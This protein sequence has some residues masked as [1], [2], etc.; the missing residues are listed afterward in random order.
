MTLREA[1]P[2]EHEIG[3]RYY[4]SDA[5]GVGGHLRDS[6]ADFRV[7]ELEAFDVEPVEADTGSYPHLVFRATLDGWD[8]NDFARELANALGVSRERVSWAGTKDKYAVTTQLFSVKREANDLPDLRDAEVEVLGRAGRPVLFGDL[9]GNAFEVVVRDPVAPANAD[10]VTDQLQAFGGV[11]NYFGHQRFGTRRAVTHEVGLAVVR[12]DWEG[13][14]LRYVGNPSERERPETREARQYVEETRDWQ[15]ALDRLPGGLRYERAMCHE[16][17]ANGADSPDDFRAALETLPSN[18]QRLLVHA[19][20]SYLYNEMLSRR[21]E[22]GLPFDR[23]VAGDVVCFTDRDAPA[24]LPVPDPDREQRVTEARVRTVT[25]HCER[26]RAFVTAPLV[27]TETE[28]AEGEQGD[29]ERAVM[30]EHDL[31]PT[32]FDLPG[33]FGSAGTRRAI[34]LPVSPAV[35]HDPLTFSFALPKG[36]YATV[37]L[38]EYLKT[39]PESLA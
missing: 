13:A 1:H 28:F 30:A 3:M 14:L 29:I 2:I 12:D 17:V 11:P 23:P 15:G 38:R 27:G 34:L 5:D 18:V 7:R 21:L 26:G 33:E 16:L 35:T 10:A 24:D 37:V 32:D 8:T 25:R 20:Q 31:S 22:A 6:P 4:V 19:A 39:N 9:A 36:S